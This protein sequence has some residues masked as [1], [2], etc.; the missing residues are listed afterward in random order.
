[1]AD[2]R[3]L[4]KRRAVVEEGDAPNAAAAAD[5][6][7]AQAFPDYTEPYDRPEFTMNAS[8]LRS[9][10]QTMRSKMSRRRPPGFSVDEVIEGIVAE[11]LA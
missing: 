5:N 2:R 4:L 8:A 1:M 6:T 11:A 3:Y 10:L 7:A 9:A